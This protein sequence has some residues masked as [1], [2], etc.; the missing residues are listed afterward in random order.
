MR[1]TWR[2]LPF[3]ILTTAFVLVMTACGIS[4][5]A[6][7]TGGD[8]ATVSIT[9]TGPGTVTLGAQSQ[10]AAT[11]TGSSDA[12]V[13]WSVN[14]VAG[15]NS[16]NGSISAG[17]L[18]SAPGSAPQSPTVTITA[19]SAASPSV[20]KS[21]PVALAA[22]PAPPIQQEDLTVAIA[23]PTSLT[24]GSSS[25]YV[26][27]VN[28]SNNTAVSWSVNG[29]PGG[30]ATDGVVSATG[31]YTAPA[32]APEGGEVTIAAVS[33]ADPSVSG[34][35][36]V[37]LT[38]P[39][40]PPGWDDDGSGITLLLSGATTITLGSSSQYTATVTGSTDTSVTWTVNGVAG[41]NSTVGT[42]SNSGHYTAPAKQTASKNVTITATSNADSSVSQGLVVGLVAPP[43]SGGGG[44]GSGVTLSVSGAATVT[45]G[46]SAQYTA[47][48][49][50]STNIGVIWSVN[51]AVG[52]N[53]IFG[54]IS[55]K[56]RYTAPSE[57][58]DS[59]EVAI[60]ATSVADPSVSRGLHVALADPV[61]PPGGGGSSVTLAVNGPT[62][63]TLGDSSQYAA[64]V[65]GATNTGVTWSVNGIA[66]GNSSIG[67]I[68]HAGLY[69]APTNHSAP[70][71]VT[72]TG[73]SV[74]D[75]SVASSLLVTLVASQPSISLT[76]SG[77]ATVTLGTSSQYSA[78]VTGSTNT[79][80]TWSVNGV[81]GGNSSIGRIS[82]K[83]KYTAPTQQSSPSHVMIT[84]TS[85][86]DPSIAESVAVALV[87]PPSGPGGNGGGSTVT[88][89]L[90]GATV[91]TLGNTAQYTATVTGNSDVAVAWSI[92][93]VT[94]GDAAVGKISTQGLYTAPTS[95][96][97][98]S[99]ITIT[100][101]SMAD[102]SVSQ[103][104]VVTLAPQSQSAV[105]LTLSGP[106][107]VVVGTT[108]QYTAVV[109]GSTNTGAT[110]SVD[111][112]IGG[113]DSVGNIST[114]GLYTA[115][116]TAPS[117]GTVTITATSL[118]D[119]SVSQTM[120]VTL[121]ASTT[122]NVTLTL[123]GATQVTLGISSQY[124]AVV[125]G[126][127]NTGVSWSVNKVAG[128]NATDGFIST[129]GL[130]TAPS[131]A[132]QPSTVTIMATSSA[133]PTV[134][135]SIVVTLIAPTGGS[136]IPANA[137]K[138]ADLN[139]SNKWQWKHD[140]GTPGS[141]NGTTSYPVGGISSDDAAR[142]F[143]MTYTAGGGEIYHVSFAKDTSATHFV[144]DANVYVVNP[145]QLKNLEMDMNDVM[146]N[147]QT[148]ILATQC[149]GY[150]KSWEYT[151]R[152]GT[153]YH[154]NPSNIPCDPAQ[155]TPNTWHHI[156]IASHR[157]NSGNSYYDWI[158]FD[159]KYTNF[160]N[161]G[162]TNGKNLGWAV[163]DLLI[164]FQID[165]PSKQ[166]GSNTIY[167]DQI[168]VWRW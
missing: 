46:T 48:V 22:P 103:N 117:T 29:V 129:G 167:T 135:K 150:S 44:S 14:G 53:S 62:T 121:T 70:A 102:S 27:T 16:A 51:G 130:Y 40:L 115:P 144:Y 72:I 81:A 105:T 133:D 61:D 36:T 74:A 6:F 116:A 120:T 4:N 98:S 9:L 28:G 123:S 149:S 166:N 113:D 24:L 18:Y 55:S 3:S 43:P 84:A 126:S 137:I 75:P 21:L 20:S 155:W 38:A 143:Y 30:D 91:V 57:Q 132:P 109:T 106:T 89:A 19:T 168:F 7:L 140:P 66:G 80:V 97:P 10:Y 39:P 94:G 71:K 87:A 119:P 151:L 60:T 50:G 156:Q 131:T 96:P 8:S 41:G 104:L 147:G 37:T 141:S 33:A 165:G 153:G 77:A 111:G 118:A 47:T 63:V 92:N 142:E 17:G 54:T 12:T 139:A 52:G 5:P 88:L 35:M 26:A 112:L 49:A 1:L 100:A 158:G 31:V 13:T 107:S 114:T 2:N 125:T 162:G 15:G 145:S 86:A 11:V 95:Q 45:L 68:S 69:I 108:A 134:A 154:W 110:W 161:A 85:N 122:P 59:P 73:T 25:A 23:G 56:G 82:A 90:S 42:I 124:T 152:S 101:T 128:G 148:V 79:G 83:G 65:T 99:K 67:T 159:G 127:A 34:G 157:D 164:N 146:S 93:G 64:I 58:P 138:S 136:R 163:G 160:Q 78:V 76:V 32:T